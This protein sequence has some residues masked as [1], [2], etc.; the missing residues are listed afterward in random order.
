M[1]LLNV[2]GTQRI[3]QNQPAAIPSGTTAMPRMPR[4][5]GM[6]SDSRQRSLSRS[7]LSQLIR[8]MASE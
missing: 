7:M 8:P 6:S 5:Q 2:E 1:E 3:A 4:G